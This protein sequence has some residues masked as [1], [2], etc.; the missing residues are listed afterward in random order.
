MLGLQIGTSLTVTRAAQHLQPLV[1]ITVLAL[2][3]AVGVW[4]LVLVPAKERLAQAQTGF[5]GAHQTER[6][7]HAARSTQEHLKEVWTQL[8]VRKDFTNL[9][10]AIAELAKANQVEVPGMTYALQDLERGLP[11]K[12]SLSF[13]AIGE[14]AAIRRFIHSLETSGSYLYIESLDAARATGRHS[15]KGRNASTLVQ[16]TVKVVTFLRPGP[17]PSGETT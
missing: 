5:D 1:L 4:Q 13:R 2:G 7:V 9:A 3:V 8:P 15:G 12:G 14:Y 11:L 10:A 6:R 17:A 16:F